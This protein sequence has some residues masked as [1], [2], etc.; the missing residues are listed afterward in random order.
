[1][2]L[3]SMHARALARHLTKFTSNHSQSR[4]N[5]IT[6]ALSSGCASGSILKTT[7]GNLGIV[8]CVDSL[9]ASG[10]ISMWSATAISHRQLH[11]T[12]N[13]Q[14]RAR[15]ASG[16]KDDRKS[17]Q[18]EYDSNTQLSNPFAS[19]FGNKDSDKASGTRE[20]TQ[21]FQPAHFKQEVSLEE[22]IERSQLKTLE[23]KETQRYVAKVFQTAGSTI[24]VAT[25]TSVASISLGVMVT[26]WIPALASIVPLFMFYNTTEATNPT[27]RKAL[28]GTFTALSGFS[29]APLLSYAVHVNPM[30]VPMALGGTTLIFL[31]A[32]GA[33]L[34]AP[35]ASMLRFGTLLGGGAMV[36]MGAS[37]FGIGQYAM[38]GAVSP[39]LFS[40]TLYGG[41]GLMT[42]FVAYDTHNIIEEYKAGSRD[43]LRHSLDVFINFMG[44]FRRLLYILTMRED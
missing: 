25:A 29:L 39:M 38:T 10:E 3:I 32:S 42:C 19:L 31:G 13:L 18:A 6:S 4:Q 12:V 36:L 24:G 15:P 41:L 26:P 35:R 21:G 16:R 23:D 17:T 20:S 7:P 5:L 1:M 40:F 27:Y 11:N 22:R 44:I 9:R 8:V 43:Y 2:A 33:A 37:L 28:V 30:L 34:L 14:A